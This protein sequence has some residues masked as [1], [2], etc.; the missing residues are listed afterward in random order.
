M[1]DK[2]YSMLGLGKKAGYLALG[3]TGVIQSIKRDKSHLIILA[4][5]ATDNTK[6]RIIPLCIKHKVPYYIIGEK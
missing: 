3:E 1:I 6:D 4:S 5:D 2:M